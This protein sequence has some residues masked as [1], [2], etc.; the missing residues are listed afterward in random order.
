MLEIYDLNTQTVI[1]NSN[2]C[3]VKFYEREL[4]KK[5]SSLNI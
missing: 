2:I 1:E 5:L 4:L 3:A